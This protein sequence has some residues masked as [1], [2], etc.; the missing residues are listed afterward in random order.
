[1]EEVFSVMKKAEPKEDVKCENCSEL[2]SI[3]FCHQCSEYICTECAKAHKKMHQF[4]SHEVVSIESFRT[5]IS[6][7][8][9]S[10][11]PMV[12]KEVKCG[13]HKDE[14]LKLYCRD[15]HMLVCRD[16]IIIDH[17][18]H[19]YVF[20]VDAAPKCKSDIKAKAESVEEISVGLKSTV[21]SLNDS[22]KKLNEHSTA[23]MK[24][25][26]DAVDRITSKLMQKRKELKE[27]ACRKFNEVKKE[28]A[29][30]E[31]NA[32]LAVGEVESLLEFM[33][34]NLDKATDQEVL[35]LEKQM[36]DQVNRVS[37]LYSDPADKFL[38]LPKIPW[39]KVQCGVRIEQVIESDIS[40]TDG[41]L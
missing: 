34:R 6:K 11:F 19:G 22:E 30:K 23:T 24:A 1:M 7:S 8:A 10:A 15:C 29:T 38:C 4:S 36:D 17:K 25:I 39:L 27:E 16:C 13:K 41:M 14:P 28:I 37:Q 9:A 18:D 20:V 40:I 5:T 31:K 3:A 33:I 26:D 32:Q 2:P 35:S 12:Q 21:K